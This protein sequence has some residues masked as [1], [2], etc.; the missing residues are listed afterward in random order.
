MSWLFQPLLPSAAQLLATV[1]GTTGQ[2]KYWNGSSWTAKPVKFYNGSWT[3]KP[4]KYYNGS[5]WVT[6]TY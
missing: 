3:T 5:T 2:I 4:L 1:G 6:T